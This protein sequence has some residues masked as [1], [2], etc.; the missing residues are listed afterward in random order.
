MRDETEW[1]ETINSGW[2]T[3]IQSENSRTLEIAKRYIFDFDTNKEAE[4]LYGDGKCSEKIIEVIRER[5]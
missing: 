5:L 3:L 4:S 1:V 2:N